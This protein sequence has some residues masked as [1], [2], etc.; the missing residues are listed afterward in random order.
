MLFHKLE[1]AF[2]KV[3]QTSSWE[4]LLLIL[5][6]IWGT[7]TKTK[8]IVSQNGLVTKLCAEQKKKP[9]KISESPNTITL[10][11]YKGFTFITNSKDQWQTHLLFPVG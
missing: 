7:C 4:Q 1:E 9:L 11:D 5:L 8:T 10:L 2:L 6:C 3:Q